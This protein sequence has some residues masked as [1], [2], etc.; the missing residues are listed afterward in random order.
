MK[1]FVTKN[2]IIIIIIFL[3]FSDENVLSLNVFLAKNTIQGQKYFVAKK[4]LVY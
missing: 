1:N 3:T 4:T 2:P